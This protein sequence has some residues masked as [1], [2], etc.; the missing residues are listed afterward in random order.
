M[1]FFLKFL[2]HKERSTSKFGRINLGFAK[3]LVSAD[4]QM[5]QHSSLCGVV[6]FN[7]LFRILDVLV[8]PHHWHAVGCALNSAPS[9]GFDPGYEYG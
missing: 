1:L 5:M 4:A 8:G 6:V 3:N 9:R 2:Y 7:R